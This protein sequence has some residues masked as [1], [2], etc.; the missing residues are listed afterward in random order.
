M[1]A[2]GLLGPDVHG[3]AEIPLAVGDV[4]VCRRNDSGSGSRTALVAAYARS[5]MTLSCLR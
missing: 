1:R 3:L 4:V 5:P 2:A